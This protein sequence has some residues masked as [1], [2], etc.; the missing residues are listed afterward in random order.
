MPVE[1]NFEGNFEFWRHFLLSSVWRVWK[2]SCSSQV[3][4]VLLSAG[5]KGLLL[6]C[7]I[8]VTVFTRTTEGRKEKGEQQSACAS[9]LFTLRHGA[10]LIIFQLWFECR[11]QYYSYVVFL[12]WDGSK[13]QKYRKHIQATSNCEFVTKIGVNWVGRLIA[14]LVFYYFYFLISWFSCWVFNRS[15]TDRKSSKCELVVY[16]GLHG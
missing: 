16:P 9:L 14:S 5:M 11:L 3:E 13:Y 1:L 2:L 6:D 12:W 4:G 8:P 10:I 7:I 15:V